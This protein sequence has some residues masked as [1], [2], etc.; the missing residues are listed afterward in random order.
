MIFVVD[1][2][3]GSHEH[4]CSRGQCNAKKGSRCIKDANGCAPWLSAMFG[5]TG[6]IDVSSEELSG[7][8]ELVM[9]VH[10]RVGYFGVSMFYS[11]HRI[12]TYE[13]IAGCLG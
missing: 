13:R 5:E 2:F 10:A 11:V 12:S 4:V 7:R 1:S 3:C 8:Q 6:T 9:R